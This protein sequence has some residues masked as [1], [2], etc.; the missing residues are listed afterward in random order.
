MYAI[1]VGAMIRCTTPHCRNLHFWLFIET[2][3]HVAQV[4]KTGLVAKNDPELLTFLTSFPK[5]EV[6]PQALFQ[7]VLL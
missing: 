4:L 2:G 1:T 3:S 6:T 5:A 7:A